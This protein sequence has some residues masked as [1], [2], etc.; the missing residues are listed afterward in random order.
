MSE[1]IRYI[2]FALNFQIVFAR[3]KPGL[4]SRQL[5]GRDFA[6]H[7]RMSFSS[8]RRNYLLTPHR[9]DGLIEWLVEDDYCWLWSL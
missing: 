2:K 3:A 9:R 6:G 1:N 5:S 7:N 4:R 8:R